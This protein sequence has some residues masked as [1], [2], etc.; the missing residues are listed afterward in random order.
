MEGARIGRFVGVRVAVA[1]CW[2]ALRKKLRNLHTKSQ[3]FSFCSSRDLHVHPD[4]QTDGFEASQALINCER[5]I[6]SMPVTTHGTLIIGLS[7]S[8]YE[9]A[10]GKDSLYKKHQ[11]T[12]QELY[13]KTLVVTVNGLGFVPPWH[14]WKQRWRLYVGTSYR[15][16][17]LSKMC[18][19]Y[20]LLV[21]GYK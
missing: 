7:S 5:F 12:H 14:A 10:D 21:I 13:I 11:T 8:Q 3:L 4:G 17:P 15:K 20:Q 18:P 16:T 9:C 1:P 19:V 6:I 2:L